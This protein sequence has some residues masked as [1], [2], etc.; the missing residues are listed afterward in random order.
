MAT[1]KIKSPLFIFLILAII[2][3]AFLV[4]IPQ[5]ALAAQSDNGIALAQPSPTSTASPMPSATLAPSA[6][7]ISTVQ[8]PTL[9]S[10]VPSATENSN[11]IFSC[12]EAWGASNSQ[13]R[14]AAPWL[15]TAFTK[16]SDLNTK[17][18]Y[19]Y[20]SGRLLRYG[21]VTAPDCPNNGLTADGNSTQCGV[22]TAYSKVIEWQNLF[23]DSILQA[24]ST[25]MIPPVV[26]KGIFAQESQFWPGYY[27]NT[28][29]AGLGHF[30]DNGADTTL[31]WNYH[32]YSLVCASG[33][34]QDACKKTY[35]QFAPSEQAMLRGQLFSQIDA[36]CS[37]CAG[38]VS[39][40]KANQS[41]AVF[42]QA[43]YAHCAQTGQIIRNTTNITP[44]KS[45]SYEDLWKI[46]LADYNAGPGCI[47]NAVKKT[48]SAGLA[49]TWANVSQKLDA[50]C[51]G[52]IR[53]VTSIETFGSNL[54]S[55]LPTQAPTLSPTRT[56]TSLPTN[57]PAPTSG[58]TQNP[59]A[60]P[61]STS[62]ST[63]TN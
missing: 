42:S 36:T 24:S 63:T 11:Q 34:D 30:T 8:K 57:T 15:S 59:T 19:E 10:I 18:K 26:L 45:T 43:I 54:N 48:K 28:W 17:V 21:L 51:L 20:L 55:P 5:Q 50:N 6:T 4:A 46:T 27:K 58:P 56:E 44:A 32:L 39:I 35:F 2:V 23:N 41:V 52:A 38:G 16:A 29:E 12:A 37:T 1:N 33:F 61:T 60:T 7:V 13:I 22:E 49:I 25:Y 3:G 62:Q 14:S 47:T 53:Y 31:G 40:V 9:Q